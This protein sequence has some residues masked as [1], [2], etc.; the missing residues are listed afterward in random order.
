LSKNKNKNDLDLAVLEEI[1]WRVDVCH[2]K[3]PKKVTLSL[4]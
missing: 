4:D 2:R 3:V 1:E